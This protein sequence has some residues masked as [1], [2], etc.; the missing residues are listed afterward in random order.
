VLSRGAFNEAQPVCDFR[1]GHSDGD[2]G[3]HLQLSLGEALRVVPARDQPAPIRS[4]CEC[5][6]VDMPRQ[7]QRASPQSTI[8]LSI[9]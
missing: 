9:F 2:E 5:P 6:A 8:T 7:E 3:E 1:V 4:G